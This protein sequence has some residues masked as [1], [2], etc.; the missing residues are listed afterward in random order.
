MTAGIVVSVILCPSEFADK[1]HAL[2]EARIIHRRSRKASS[3][4][5]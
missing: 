3:I 5:V 1:N 4:V 2:P